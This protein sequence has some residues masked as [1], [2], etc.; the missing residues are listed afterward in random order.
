MMDQDVFENSITKM[1]HRIEEGDLKK[2]IYIADKIDWSE[3]KDVNLLLYVSMIYEDYKDYDSAKAL[4]EY[5]YE[6]A[7]V[8]AKLFFALCNIN[9]KLGDMKKAKDYYLSFCEVFP[10][11]NKKILLKYYFLKKKG[12]DAT[13][14]CR[15]LEEYIE[16]EKTEDTLFEL[17]TIYEEMGEKEKIIKTCEYIIEFF[18]V[19]KT[20]YG[21]KALELKKKY[22]P[23]SLKEENLLINYVKE[24]G[25]EEHTNIVYQ[26]IKRPD[27]KVVKENAD[28][29]IK[30]EKI[31]REVEKKEDRLDEDGDEIRPV[32]KYEPETMDGLRDKKLTMA[33]MRRE[34]NKTREDT[35]KNSAFNVYREKSFKRKDKNMKF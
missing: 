20:G 18:G 23:L 24:N 16:E 35:T 22:A 34:I 14:K 31:N 28:N 1:K 11:D 5:A 8:K 15:V 6:V 26:N 33:F 10:N 21:R 7:P 2:A 9:I 19:K 25:E 17:A 12:A 30:I 29:D 27:L 4:I 3:V 13:Q 32:I